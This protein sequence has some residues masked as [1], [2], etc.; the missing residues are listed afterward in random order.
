MQGDIRG[1]KTS[2]QRQ[3][4]LGAQVQCIG[5]IKAVGFRQ[6]LNIS[7]RFIE[8]STHTEALGAASDRIEPG[9]FKHG[10]KIARAAKVTVAGDKLVGMPEQVLSYK[11]LALQAAAVLF[12][13]ADV[14]DGF[15][16]E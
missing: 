4:Q 3:G 6:C 10:V 8:K 5:E 1:I 9:Q 15:V 14:I 7:G 16:A 12:P 2:G 11:Q 13:S